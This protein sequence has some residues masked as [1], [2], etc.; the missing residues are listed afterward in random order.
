MGWFYEHKVGTRR[1]R[2]DDLL[3]IFTTYVNN[4]C[5][6]YP[7]GMRPALGNLSRRDRVVLATG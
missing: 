5:P 6:F 4:T 1:P 2:D 7:S 3:L